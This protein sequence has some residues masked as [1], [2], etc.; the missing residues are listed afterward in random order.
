MDEKML[1]ACPDEVASKIEELLDVPALGRDPFGTRL[2]YVVKAQLQPMV[3]VKDAESFGFRPSRIE[4]REDMGDPPGAMEAELVD[5][6]NRYLE[7]HQ[8]LKNHPPLP[9]QPA[10]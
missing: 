10:H 6:A 2:D 5:P 3:R 4:D 1:P 9:I 7:R 8:P